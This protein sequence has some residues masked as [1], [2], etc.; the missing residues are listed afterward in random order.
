M[1]DKANGGILDH[2]VELRSKQYTYK[3]DGELDGP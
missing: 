1:K 2:F 3:N